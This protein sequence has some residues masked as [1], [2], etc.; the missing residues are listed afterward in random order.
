VLTLASLSRA[1]QVELEKQVLLLHS[2][3]KL[4]K[5]DVAQ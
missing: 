3:L 5:L 4:Q 1:V 2:D